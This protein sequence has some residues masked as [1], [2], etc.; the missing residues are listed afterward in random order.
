MCLFDKTL[1]VHCLCQKLANALP[2]PPSARPFLGTAEGL[3]AVECRVN[4]TNT[5][6][7]LIELCQNAGELCHGNYTSFFVPLLLFVVRL[8]VSSSV[9]CRFCRTAEY[10][11]LVF[12]QNRVER[13]LYTFRTKERLSEVHGGLLRFFR[14]TALPRLSKWLGEAAAVEDIK[15]SLQLHAHLVLVYDSLAR[16][17]EG[18]SNANVVAFL[19]SISFIVAWYSGDSEPSTSDFVGP[20]SLSK[21]VQEGYAVQGAG[22]SDLPIHEAFAAFQR[23][24]LQLV[25]RFERLEQQV[26]SGNDEAEDFLRSTLN[27]IVSTALRRREDTLT[28][29]TQL[30]GDREQCSAEFE[31]PHPYA[32]NTTYFKSIHFPGV[33]QIILKFD[34]RC[35]TNPSDFLTVFKVRVLGYWA[36]LHWATAETPLCP[37]SAFPLYVSG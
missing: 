4:A 1:C 36:T 20:N 12:C 17:T 15:A 10:Q 13:Y 29:W 16:A 33:S 18:P 24:R 3:L 26:V 6:Q 8:A 37:L 5:L 11:P 23:N 21:A 35:S 25:T 32:Q 28:R 9:K 27:S 22:S 7:P 30:T 31:T 19:E 14:A 2:F 34:S